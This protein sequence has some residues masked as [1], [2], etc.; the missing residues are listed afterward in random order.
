MKKFILVAII[1]T[2]FL[3]SFGQSVDDEYYAKLNALD[4]YY[5]PENIRRNISLGRGYDL[6]DPWYP[7]IADESPFL[8]TPTPTL[9]TYLKNVTKTVKLN[10]GTGSNEYTMRYEDNVD[11]RT[12]AQYYHAELK[13]KGL[14]WG[15]ET[16]VDY[17]KTK[18]NLSQGVH[19]ILENK[20]NIPNTFDVNTNW[21]AAPITETS[22]VSEANKWKL[23]KQ[24]YGSHYVSSFSYG[25]RI[26]ILAFANT[27]TTDSKLTLNAAFNAWMVSGKFSAEISEKIK[28][29][30]ATIDVAIFC[31]EIKNTETGS[32]LPFIVRGLTDVLKFL[33]DLKDGKIIV[34]PAPKTIS[35]KSYFASVCTKYP[36]SCRLFD[37]KTLPVDSNAVP[38][39]TILAWNPPAQNIRVVAG[40]TIIVPPVGGWAVCDKRNH[41]L[42][43]R[44]P[45]LA[46]KFLMGTSEPDK[47]G[48][49]GGSPTHQ[50]PGST[51]GL[52]ASDGYRHNT[53]VRGPA[54]GLPEVTGLAHNHTLQTGDGSSIPPYRMVVYIIKL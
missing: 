19:F 1:A 39:G 26:E 5:I 43:P 35:F 41:D 15:V 32:S 40:Q 17:V 21:K 52:T 10:T 44:V 12:V 30:N 2:N 53:T 33:D 11:E 29:S 34:T 37:V 51:T 27:A 8:A 24:K 3:T 47:I 7:I 36:K 14:S 22:P 13:A 9:T 38:R 42:N 54:G 20:A 4:L 23:F 28:Q 49:E 50:H 25:Y 48:T 18:Y 6:T 16:S 46:N 45:D 31:N